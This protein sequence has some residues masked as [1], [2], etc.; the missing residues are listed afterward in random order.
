MH[1][2]SKLGRIGLAALVLTCGLRA[3]EVSAAE[4][5]AR[6]VLTAIEKAKA[7]LVRNQDGNGSWASQDDRY[8][9]GVTSL[10]LLALL[11]AGMTTDD[12]PVADALD[13][14]R[15]IKEPAPMGTYDLSLMIMAL[16]TAKDGERD[17]ARILTL[18][19]KLENGQLQ[20]G[21]NAGSWSYV[22]NS[23]GFMNTG[24]DRSNGQFAILGLRDAANAGI[25]VDRKVWEKARRHWRASQNADGGWGYRALRNRDDSYG[26]MTVA[27]IATLTITNSMLRDDK[28]LNEDGTPNCCGDVEEDEALARAIRW[29]ESRFSVRHNPSSAVWLLYYLYGLERAGRLSGTRFFGTHDWYREG[30]RYLVDG[31][32]NVY[33]SWQGVGHLEGNPVIGSSLALLF[34]SKGLSSVLI[35]KLEYGPRNPKRPRRPID[36]NWNQHHDDV[37]NLTS[38]VSSLPEWP[39]LLTWQ[40]LDFR[41]VEQFGGVRDMLQAPVLYIAGSEAPRFTPE[42]VELLKEYVNQGG[43]IFAVAN[44]R[45]EDFGFGI[46]HLVTQMFPGGESELKELPPDH[47]IYRSEYPL[48]PDGIELYGADFGCRTAVVYSP[49]DLSCLWDK[50][51]QHDP[52]G[53][54]A[55]EKSVIIRATKIGVNIVAYATG[56]EPPPDKLSQVPELAKADKQNEIERGFL[57]IA[58][59]RHA[60]TWDAA[61]QAL[62]NLLRALNRT[63]G[64][65]ASTRQRNLPASDPNIFKYPV[66]YMH[67]RTSYRLSRREI[68]QL[69]LY[70]SRGGVLFADACCGAKQFDRSFREFIG[71]LFPNDELQRIPADHDMFTERVGYDLKT[72]RR[73]APETDDPDAA[74]NVVEQAGEPFLE[75][76]AID[77]RY[78]VIYSKYDIS[79][80]LE[81]QASVACTGYVAEDAVK[82]AVNVVLYAMLQDVTFAEAGQ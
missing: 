82:L 65:S 45:S 41:K 20:A 49:E 70:L 17:K 72:V 43:F 44:C 78:A 7:F 77:G 1:R 22:V 30:A 59:L 63:V 4:L 33:G 37:R 32:S 74:L 34:L 47:P 12:Q 67:G 55:Q 61:P 26:S 40:I 11:N 10:A 53:R 71:Q 80:A 39:K 56:R 21:P 38:L 16:A 3:G 42:Q 8:G 51:M 57:Q 48:E 2:V 24:G 36:N 9:I 6:E 29:L 69:Q 79:C 28:V 31:Q 68:E 19:Q 52:P 62:R 46:R 54:T 25:A 64:L 35:N 23:T 5:T 60:G 13:Y 50:W 18:A 81:R 14:L 76:I 58:K 27:G 75:G 73:R 66:L 15:A